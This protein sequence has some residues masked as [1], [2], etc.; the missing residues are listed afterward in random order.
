[1]TADSSTEQVKPLP[2]LTERLRSIFA[3]PLTAVAKGIAQLGI[4]PNAI[5]VGGLILAIVPA[6]LAVFGRYTWAGVA[7]LVSVPFDALD[8]A[9]AR[10]TGTVS[11]FG[12]FLD[13]TLDRYG[14]AVLLT[15]IGYKMAEQRHLTGVVLAFVA[16]FGSLMVS[17]TRARS[18]GLTIDNKVGLMTRVER[19]IITIFGLLSGQIVIMLWVLAIATHFTVAQRIVHTYL[20]SRT[21]D[22]KL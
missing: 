2:T 5:T 8:G 13:S 6:V 22:Q 16:L 18:E 19:V 14:E 11:K 12:A 1:M 9:V 10:Q 7:Y 3:G 15:A 17:Y 20:A 4:S 21:S